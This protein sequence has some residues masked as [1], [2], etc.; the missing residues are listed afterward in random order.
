MR[1]EIFFRG[2]PSARAR[3]GFRP[4]HFPTAVR[5]SQGGQA[6]AERSQECLPLA[7]AAGVRPTPA[8]QGQDDGIGI[9]ADG[10]ASGGA[11]NFKIQPPSGAGV[12]A[13]PAMTHGKLH[14]KTGEAYSPAAQERRGFHFA[15]IDTARAG[16]KCLDAQ[17]PSPCSQILGAEFREEGWPH[18]RRLM[19]ARVSFGEFRGRFRVGEVQAAAA[20]DEKLSPHGWLRIVEGD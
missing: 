17:T 6:D 2:W 9:H 12:K 11:C 10:F 19:P 13:D 4:V 5:G 15:R 18:S 16:G 14:A 7:V 3:T 20:C 8:A 1:A